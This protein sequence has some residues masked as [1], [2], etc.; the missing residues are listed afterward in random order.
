MGPEEAA[1]ILTGAGTGQYLRSE[2]FETQYAMKEVR[3][4]AGKATKKAQVRLKRIVRYLA[5]HRQVVIRL[6]LWADQ[7]WN[8]GSSLMCPMWNAQ[9]QE[10]Y[11][12]RSV[13]AGG[14]QHWKVSIHTVSGFNFP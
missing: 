1:T 7:Q 11:D 4:K 6:R 13:H 5:S 8:S 9:G 14:T 3:P 2:R 10:Q 12:R